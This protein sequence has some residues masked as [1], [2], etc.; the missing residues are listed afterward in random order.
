MLE[1]PELA[2]NGKKLRFLS[3]SHVRVAF[4][5]T[6]RKGGAPR[7]HTVSLVYRHDLQYVLSSPTSPKCSDLKREGRYTLQT[8]TPQINAEIE[9]FNIARCADRIQD[10][11]VRQVAIADP[12]I[13]VE[14]REVLFELYLEKTIYTR[15][16]HRDT[17]CESPVQRKWC[18][19]N[20]YDK[21]Q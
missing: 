6:L 7:L 17:A 18:A 11:T 19:M 4:L 12:K 21:S 16:I 1:E 8:Y 10:A 14:L 5:A 13:R 15:L 9:E 2:E 3:H 20:N